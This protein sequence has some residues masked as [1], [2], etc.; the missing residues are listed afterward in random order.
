MQKIII[1]K[2]GPLQEIDLDVKDAMLFIGLQAMGK[3]TIV[4][5]IFFFKLLKPCIAIFK[6]LLLRQELYL[7]VPIQQTSKAPNC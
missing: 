6:I 4:K 5:T 7:H 2:L 1:K 3:S